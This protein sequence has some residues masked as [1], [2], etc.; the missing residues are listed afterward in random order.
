MRPVKRYQRMLQQSDM[1]Y[2]AVQE[3]IVGH[4]DRMYSELVK[5]RTQT[6]FLAR[7]L[8][9]NTVRG[10]YL[11]GGVGR[12]KTRLMDMFYD[13]IS[14]RRRM[15]LHFHRFMQEVHS[16]LKRYSGQRNPLTKVGASIASETE[17]LCFDDF[18]VE[19][20][21]DA[22]LLEGLLT[23][24]FARGVCLVITSN[25]APDKL[26]ENGLQ[27]ARF[28]PAIALLKQ[29][30]RILEMGAGS[31]YRLLTLKNDRLYHCPAGAEA[32]KDMEREFRSLAPDKGSRGQII[33]VEGRE[34]WTRCMADDVVWF[35]F[36]DLCEGPRSQHDYLHL[37]LEFHA[38]LL[39]DVPQFTPA[40]DA[41]ARR[42]VNLI[43]VLYDHRVKLVISAE[44]PP[45]KLYTG[46]QLRSVFRRTVSRLVEMQS[47]EYLASA[48]RYQVVQEA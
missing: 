27:R 35:N 19:E 31:D 14:G 18:F 11:W 40:L 25:I 24:L 4:L 45:E 37:A 22:M 3:V 41:A 34:L 46:T 6:G 33:H 42:F 39:S 43:D 12:G 17:V 30:C 44:T 38:L 8:R 32:D 29:H 47:M 16:A 36:R 21:G 20:I 28:L 23:E 7:L 5:R 1:H 48:H 13:S 15:R 9:H 2:D 26:Y 10:L